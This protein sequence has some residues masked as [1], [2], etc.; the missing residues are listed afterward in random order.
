MEREGDNY[1]NCNW[2][3]VTVTKGLLKGLENLEVGGRVETIQTTTLL[4]T[5]RILRRVLETCGHSNSSGR[6][7]ANADVKNYNN[8]NTLLINKRN[9]TQNYQDLPS[10]EEFE[11]RNPISFNSS[12]EYYQWKKMII[13]RRITSVSDETFN[14]K[15]M[16]QTDTK[17]VPDKTCLM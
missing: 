8:D 5:A 1:T 2:W 17:G 7:S 12:T 13:H 11:K 10:K 14:H 9:C 6:P 3:F 15:Q 4:R 16:Q